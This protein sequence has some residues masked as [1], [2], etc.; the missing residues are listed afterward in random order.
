MRFGFNDKWEN[1]DSV[2]QLG[3]N[4]AE[5]DDTT[6]LRNGDFVWFCYD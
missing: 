2:L 5:T 4:C 1:F 3:L 6:L